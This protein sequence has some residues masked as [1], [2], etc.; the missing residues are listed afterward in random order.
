[1]APARSAKSFSQQV[2][3]ASRARSRSLLR[4]PRRRTR[5]VSDRRLGCRDVSVREYARTPP[6]PARSCPAPEGRGS[7]S[8]Q[9]AQRESPEPGAVG[10]S[11]LGIRPRTRSGTHTCRS[12]QQWRRITASVRTAT[13]HAA[14]SRAPRRPPATAPR[15]V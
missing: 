14:F 9:R 2:A 15:R 12:V 10:V 5:R 1:M 8:G 6:R 13:V 4:P 11:G 7:P 3:T